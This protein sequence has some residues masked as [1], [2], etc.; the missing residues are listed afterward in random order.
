MQVK[1][2]KLQWVLPVARA[3]IYSS[4]AQG[5]ISYEY[6]IDRSS[7]YETVGRSPRSDKRIPRMYLPPKEAETTPTIIRETKNE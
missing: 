1:K 5:S 3:V 7:R 6:L 2:S 4:C